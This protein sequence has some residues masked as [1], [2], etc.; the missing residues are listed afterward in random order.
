MNIC[1]A[2][3]LIERVI[4][5]R[6]ALENAAQDIDKCIFFHSQYGWAK[7]KVKKSG[8]NLKLRR[9]EN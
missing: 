1:P 2:N 8:Y 5:L 9:K 3:D 7:I 6:E 4:A